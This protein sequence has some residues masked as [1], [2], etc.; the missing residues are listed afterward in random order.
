[1]RR[2]RSMGSIRATAVL[3]VILFITGVEIA[4]PYGVS[5]SIEPVMS[6]PAIEPLK[7][8]IPGISGEY[9]PLKKLFKKLREFLSG[10]E[11]RGEGHALPAEVVN[12]KPAPWEKHEAKEAE[13]LESSIAELEK[14]LEE[15]DIEMIKAE[16]VKLLL[17]DERIRAEFNATEAKLRRLAAEGRVSQEKLKRLEEVRQNYSAS[18]EELL[19]EIE[20]VEKAGSREELKQRAAKAK[21]KLKELRREKKERFLGTELPHRSVYREARQLT[22]GESLLPGYTYSL[23]NVSSA[24]LSSLPTPAD[25]NATPEV[26]ITP[27]IESLAEMLSHDPVAMYEYVRNRFD[28]Q[29]YYGSLKGSQ[30]TLWEKAG[31]D[32]DLASLLIA[33]YRSAG[34][35][36]RYAYGTVEVPV[37][38]AMNVTGI[39]D[40]VTAANAFASGGVPATLLISGGR[41]SSLLIEHVWV[42]AYLPYGSY[43]GKIKGEGGYQWVPLDPSFKWYRYHEPAIN[44]TKAMGFNATEFISIIMNQST[45]NE[46]GYYITSVN[47]SFIREYMENLTN[48]TYA[49]LAERNLTSLTLNELLGYREIIPERLGVLPN[50][51]PYRVIEKKAEFSEL[52]D[53][54]RHKIKF[55]VY[56][57]S[58][59]LLGSLPASSPDFSVTLSMPELAGKRIT[60]SYIPATQDDAAIIEEYGGITNVPAY[61]VEMTPVLRV[62]GEAVAIGNP[63]TIGETQQFVMEFMAPGGERDRVVND[64]TVGAYYAVGLDLGNVPARLIENR[65]AELKT[66]S[67]LLNVS[68]YTDDRV[69]G[70]M[71]YTTALAYFFELDVCNDILS[72]TSGV[73]L[74]RQ[75]SEAIVALDMAVGYLFWSPYDL[76]IAGLNIDV[77]RNVYTA[78]SKSGNSEEARSFILTSGNLGSALEHGIFEQLYSVPSVSA[79]KILQVASEQGVPI[80]SINASNVDAILPRL[81]VSQEVRDAVR[82]AVVQGREVIIPERNIQYYNWTGIGYIVLDPETGAGAYMISGGLAGG[83]WAIIMKCFK[84]IYEFVA[85]VIREEIYTL[86]SIVTYLIEIIKS[87]TSILEKGAAGLLFILILRNARALALVLKPAIEIGIA[88]LTWDLLLV[89]VL[90]M[91]IITVLYIFYSLIIKKP[92]FTSCRALSRQ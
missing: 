25:L 54:L 68:G 42:E 16:K 7:L 73:F 20:D 77:D 64:V 1:M 62:E 55:E 26:I 24:N 58:S 56:Q 5:R 74:L 17:I 40:P 67:N 45:I 31:N 60:L 92:A 90:F 70:E 61:L 29:P 34:I 12:T 51:L 91:T 78:L 87:K 83:S 30:L 59:S 11:S 4:Y 13:E 48:S 15:L 44:L 52:P 82:N 6:A 75:P 2:G 72:R 76:D 10:R 21:R 35:P 65:H 39:S 19:L 57:V 53:E 84:E 33:L 3:M 63:V 41:P 50:S 66:W 27:E 28:Y 8:E 22:L 43:R 37:E 32:F 14:A 36:A 81:Q 38:W 79:V 23:V 49:Y 46:S 86:Q 69:L 71:L 85:S 18:M 47:Q 80:Y 9:F 89:L 88:A